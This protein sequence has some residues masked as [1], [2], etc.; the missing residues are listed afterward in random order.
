MRQALAVL[1]LLLLLV[2]PA[3]SGVRF[4][5]NGDGTFTD[6]KTDLVWT[7]KIKA[8]MDWSEGMSTA[9]LLHSG[10]YGIRDGS[11]EG[12]WRLPSLAEIA[13][14]TNGLRQLNTR[15]LSRPFIKFVDKGDYINTIVW[16]SKRACSYDIP[17]RELY[18]QKNSIPWLILPVRDRR[19]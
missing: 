2:A 15:V 12:D 11:K 9:R 6:T 14:L 7:P 5:N 3:F 19:K 17:H 1:A 18:C 13:E 4:V 8:R 10:Q 16:T